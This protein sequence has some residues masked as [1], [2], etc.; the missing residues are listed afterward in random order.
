MVIS[1]RILGNI[2]ISTFNP[3]VL[4]FRQIIGPVHEL[5]NSLC[6]PYA[7]PLLSA[8]REESVT[9][10]RK[11]IVRF[12]LCPQPLNPPLPVSRTIFGYV[13]Q[14]GLRLTADELLERSPNIAVQYDDICPGKSFM[15]VCMTAYAKVPKDFI[16][17]YTEE[18]S[19]YLGAYPYAKV[20]MRYAGREYG[21]CLWSNKP[22][23]CLKML[24]DMQRS[25]RHP[26]FSYY[27]SLFSGAFLD[28]IL[29]CYD[30]GRVNELK[31]TPYL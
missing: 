8:A 21:S 11:D 14:E 28:F 18:L 5:P 10:C 31:F 3:F 4:R 24:S 16:T 19:Q 6:V 26:E 12:I 17:E 27:S 25:Q 9:I 13:R 15:N 29:W 30:D 2:K 20:E 1:D 23:D 7:G 22:D